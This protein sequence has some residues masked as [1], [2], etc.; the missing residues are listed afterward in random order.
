MKLKKKYANR[1]KLFVLV[2][3][4]VFLLMFIVKLFKKDHKISY[5]VNK[6]EVVEKFYIKN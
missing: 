3:I 4:I 5:K 2:I 1:L 6:Y